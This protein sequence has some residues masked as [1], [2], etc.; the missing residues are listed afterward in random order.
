[1]WHFFH[2]TARC[3]P[4]SLAIPTPKFLNLVTSGIMMVEDG[5]HQSPVNG[6]SVVAWSVEVMC[7]NLHLS[8]DW[9]GL[10]CIE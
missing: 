9:S 7:G 5:G 6:T 1:M 2:S 3:I 10:A 8:E 4:T